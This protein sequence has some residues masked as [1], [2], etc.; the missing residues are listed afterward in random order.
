MSEYGQRLRADEK[1]V[2]GDWIVTD[3]KTV[4]DSGCE[5]I[6]WLINHYLQKV[7]DSLKY[8]AWETLYRDPDDGRYWERTYPR[9]EM[10]GGGPPKLNTIS[11]DQIRDKYGPV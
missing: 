10:H 2:T 4:G 11:S 7:S 8:G 1:S 9:S 6:E 3:G 5:R